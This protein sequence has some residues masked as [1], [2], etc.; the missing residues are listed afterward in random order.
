V[1]FLLKFKSVVEGGK[2][3][4]RKWHLNRMM[5]KAI[6]TRSHE[7]CRS[8][9]QKMMK[10]YQTIDGILDHFQQ[11][12]SQAHSSTEDAPEEIEIDC[13]PK[14]PEQ[15]AEDFECGWEWDC[16]DLSVGANLPF[17]CPEEPLI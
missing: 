3:N 15:E 2:K 1:D 16:L 9:H 6:G 8:H 17:Y 10:H 7:Q 12:P 4:R 5:S 11:T 13:T 14:A